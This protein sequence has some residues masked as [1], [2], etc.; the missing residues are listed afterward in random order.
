PSACTGDA[1]PATPSPC[2]P[3]R[4]GGSSAATPAPAGAR[5]GGAGAAT[6]AAPPA[7]NGGSPSGTS[8][9]PPW[10]PRDVLPAPPVRRVRPHH[11]HH[12]G[13]PVIEDVQLTLHQAAAEARVKP[14]TIETWIH[15]G[16]LKPIPGPRPRRLRLADVLAAEAG[17]NQKMRRKPSG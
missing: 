9:P 11:H 6:N 3:S 12:P 8:W 14:Q 16:Y 5:T 7:T 17:R 15:R 2:A 10:T 13:D 1:R 4:A